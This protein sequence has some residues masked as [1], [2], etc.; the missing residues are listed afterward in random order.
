[1]EENQLRMCDREGCEETFKPYPHNKRFCSTKCRRAWER[2][3]DYKVEVVE[4]DPATA[5]EQKDHAKLERKI[6]EEVGRTQILVDELH[7]QAPDAQD[8]FA[9]GH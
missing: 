6:R 5:V 9:R 3:N 2:A 7:A 1:M 4:T 8:R